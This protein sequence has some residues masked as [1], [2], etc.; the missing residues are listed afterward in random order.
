MAID[1]KKMLD[2]FLNS[3]MATGLVAGML[4][5]ALARRTGLGGLVKI[6]GVALVGT[7]AYQAWQRYQQQQSQL[8]PDQ[9]SQGGMRDT[10]GGVMANIPGLGDM[11][12]S[13]ENNPAA[14][15]AGFGSN[16]LSAPAQNQLGTAVLT[17]M[18]AAAKAD[19][20][21]DQT[22]SQKIFGQMEQAGLSGEEKAFL[23]GE[24]AKP[25]NIEDVAKHA[26]T[27]EVAAQLY[28]ASAIVIDQANDRE[29]DYL[30]MLAQRLNIPQGFIDQ[31]NGQ[32]AR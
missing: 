26:A 30:A 15:A 4:G 18:I 29:R 23:L 17:A 10:L 16:A 27:P 1:A 24:L 8:P 19:G 20:H 6:G 7:L 14:A 31:L 5:G 28:T 12:K 2:Q 22:E 25:L 11:M 9:R 3:G 13:A 21:V 32:M